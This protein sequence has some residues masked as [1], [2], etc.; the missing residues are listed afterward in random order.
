MFLLTALVFAAADV[1][2]VA[3]PGGGLPEREPAA[4]GMSAERLSTIDRVV[5]RGVDAGG[6]P[7]AAVVVGRKGF[8]VWS[9]GFGTLDWS[10]KSRVTAQESLYDL[11][12]LTK[13]VATTSAIMVLYDRGQIDLDAP[14]SRYLPDFQGGLRD[15]VTVRHL[16]T[17]RAGLPA[18]RELWRIAKTPA[19]AR[20][21]VMASAVKCTPGACYEYSDLGAD[22][23][24]FIAESVSGQRLDTFLQSAIYSKLNMQDT[25]FQV[26]AGDVS[27][28]APTE[29]APPRGY[30]L[31]GEV[32]DENAFALGGVAGH[33]GLFSTAADL[34][35]FAQMLLNGGSYNGVRVISDSTVTLFTRRAAG[36]RALGWDTCDGGAGCG[37]FMTERAFGHTGFTGTS[38]WIDPDRQ[39]FVILLTN[40][41]HAAR[42]RRPS[43]VIADV[44]NDLADAAV[45]AVMDDPD[46]VRAMPASFR[47]DVAQDWNRPLR[48]SRTASAA[49][50]RRAAAAKRAAAARKSSSSK[51]SSKKPTAKP[52]AAKATKAAAK[53]APVKSS[54]KSKSTSKATAKK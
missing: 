19:E 36:R 15:K 6:Y 38:L 21:A 39:M 47:A 54:A 34:S 46:G 30:P 17:H 40:R 3:L 50:R 27:R 53:K 9:R 5:R 10:A 18:G 26:P 25:Y 20:A 12:S 42:A 44:R 51:S 2:H 23:L 13:V 41:V 48:S 31:R 11:A 1:T 16:L 8:T 52:T 7:G 22:L 29:I 43:K 24:G 35:V 28:T 49:A 14:V 45:L 4:V 33:A 37:Q 32:H